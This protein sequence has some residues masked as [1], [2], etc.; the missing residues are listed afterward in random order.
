MVFY[1][2]PLSAW[3]MFP[4][5]TQFTWLIGL[6]WAGMLGMALLL[7]RIRRNTQFWALWIFIFLLPV[8][9]IVPFPVWLA[10]RYLYI[11]AV[12]GFVLV[13]QLFFEGYDRLLAPWQRRV[14]EC[15]MIA[16]LLLFAVWTQ[17]QVPVW[18]NNLTLWETTTPTC[19]TSAYC[20]HNF[21]LALLEDRQIE[22]GVRELIR[23]VEIRPGP[24]F[25]E[26]L[27]DAYSLGVGDYRQA[28]IAYRMA[29]EKAG[30][31]PSTE[32]YA[33]LARAYLLTGNLDEAERTIED[34][35]QVNPNDPGLWVIDGVL[36]WKLGNWEEAWLSL[37]RSLAITGR[38]S[39]VAGFI[40][41]YWGNAAEA[42]RMLAD[43]RSA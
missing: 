43:L 21:G 20:H 14:G 23:A 11:P 13:S 7:A 1:P 15:G 17:N 34:G 27:G 18:K 8:L 12:G 3:E 9:Q 22:H 36:Q 19:M 39:N 37:R 30:N 33:K 26:R 16:V 10:D 35:K 5:Q 41:E 25:L 28:F 40:Y 24:I 42:G 6:G 4:V 2:H 29:V 32:V 31:D 38:T